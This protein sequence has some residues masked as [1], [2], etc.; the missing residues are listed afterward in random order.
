MTNSWQGGKNRHISQTS[1]F[2]LFHSASLCSIRLFSTSFCHC[3]P[4]SF[5]FTL[6]HFASLCFTFDLLFILLHFV[7]SCSI[8]LPFDSLCFRVNSNCFA[9]P[10][11][12]AFCFIHIH[13]FYSASFCFTLCHSAPF[14]F[15]LS[16]ITFFTLPLSSFP[17]FWL[18]AVIF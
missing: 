2:T 12:A 3:Y 18:L 14:C 15:T 13:S 11:S 5:C 16:L 10:H 4:A 1:G 7:W 8:L 9:P 17:S 6:L